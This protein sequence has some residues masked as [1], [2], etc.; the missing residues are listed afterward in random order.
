[1]SKVL[2]IPDVHLKPKIFDEAEKI[3]DSGKVYSAI[4]LGDIADDFGATYDDYEATFKKAIE[5][6]KKFPTTKWCWG[7]HDF[8]YAHDIWNITGN[9]FWA[10]EIVNNSLNEINKISPLKVVHKIDNVIFSHAGIT[11]FFTEVCNSEKTEKNLDED[12]IINEINAMDVDT[13]WSDDSPLWTR[14]QIYRIKMYDKIQVIGHTPTK[15]ITQGYNWI[16]TDVYSTTRT[17]QPIGEERMIIVDT[18]T[19]IFEYAN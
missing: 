8:A 5:F 10:K 7:N 15:K 19:G 13:L 6:A 9:Q 11:D 17:G 1:M 16:S 12:F 2:V 3:L 18:E 4:Q 14:P